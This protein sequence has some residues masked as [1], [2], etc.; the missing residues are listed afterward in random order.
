MLGPGG[1]G[2]RLR[3][4]LVLQSSS[5]RCRGMYEGDGE[6]VGF[7]IHGTCFRGEMAGELKD[8]KGKLAKLHMGYVKF[9]RLSFGSDERKQ[10]NGRVTPLEEALKNFKHKKVHASFT[11]RKAWSS[12]FD[13]QLGTDFQSYARWWIGEE[14][15][16]YPEADIGD[17]EDIET[18]EAAVPGV[19]MVEN[20]RLCQGARGSSYYTVDTG[21]EEYIINV[22]WKGSGVADYTYKLAPRK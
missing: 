11:Q 20:R 6:E 16:E 2:M 5:A 4:L 18:L 1:A 7:C 17:G 15:D 12:C 19:K 10:A 13:V 22:D 9:V 14:L 3:E 21:L 8:T